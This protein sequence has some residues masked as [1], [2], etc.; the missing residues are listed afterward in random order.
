MIPYMIGKLAPNSSHLTRGLVKYV[1]GRGYFRAVFS[2]NGVKFVKHPIPPPIVERVAPLASFDK[3]PVPLRRFPGFLPTPLSFF[4]LV[5]ISV[6]ALSLPSC[7]FPYSFSFPSPSPSL[8]SLPFPSSLSWYPVLPSEPYHRAGPG[9]Y[10]ASFWLP[11]SA[12]S[13]L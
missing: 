1:P 7:S 6:L 5:P 3:L 13:C 8:F 4:V 2:Q 12:T 10:G 11:P 9:P